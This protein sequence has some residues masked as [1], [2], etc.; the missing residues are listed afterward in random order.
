VVAADLRSTRHRHDIRRV[1]TIWWLAVF[2]AALF[3]MTRAAEPLWETIR[4]LAFVQFPWRL[5]MVAAIACGAMAAMTVSYVTDPR[6]RVIGVMLLVTVAWQ[7]SYPYI[8]DARSRPRLTMRIDDAAWAGTT[9]AILMHF[10]EHAYDPVAAREPPAAGVERFAIRRGAGTVVPRLVHDDR[11]ELDVRSTAGVRIGINSHYMPGW[12]AWIDGREAAITIDGASGY[13]DA[14]VP[15][16]SHV[17]D[18]RFTDTPLRS[19]ANLLS[20]SALALWVAVFAWSARDIVR[21]SAARGIPR[22]PRD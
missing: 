21:R 8:A 6:L 17:V 16:G 19:A 14:E 1:E 4:P 22:T 18:V 20:M 9:N 7:S 10:I 15:P 3:M 12:R 2:A 13:I 5:L 11:V